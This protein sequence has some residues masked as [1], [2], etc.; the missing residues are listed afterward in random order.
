MKIRDMQIRA[1]NMAVAKGWWPAPPV[2]HGITR[3][4]REREATEYRYTLREIEQ[5]SDDA[6][7]P[8]KDTT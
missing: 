6:L 2:L 8:T 3:H 1:H 7:H 5:A 4:L